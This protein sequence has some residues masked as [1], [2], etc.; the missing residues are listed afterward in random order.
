M[1]AYAFL[2]CGSIAHVLEK[3]VTTVG[4]EETCALRLDIKGISRLHA[5]ISFQVGGADP[6][7]R[8][9][10]SSNGTFL[11]GERVRPQEPQ[12]LRHGDVVRFSAYEPTY[13]RFEL[14]GGERD[15]DAA[16]V[17]AEADETVAAMTPAR[18]PLHLPPI[19]PGR[20]GAPA[21]G[22]EEGSRPAA[23][24]RRRS[25][26]G[27]LQV[28]ASQA[29][30]GP[31]SGRSGSGAERERAA[32]VEP[33]V[34][35]NLSET[36]AWG[37]QD[38]PAMP[39]VGGGGS[40]GSFFAPQPAQVDASPRGPARQELTAGPAA[41]SESAALASRALPAVDKAANALER[42][43]R[44]LQVEGAEDS[45]ASQR[46]SQQ[47]AK[48]AVASADTNSSA[49]KR[50]AQLAKSVEQMANLAVNDL[51]RELE[52][53]A[54]RIEVRGAR[55]RSPPAA[56]EATRALVKALSKPEMPQVA[57]RP[58][59]SAASVRQKTQAEEALRAS[60]ERLEGE[61]AAEQERLEERQS[62]ARQAAAVAQQ[63]AAATSR[64]TPDA[65]QAARKAPGLL[66]EAASL[67][68]RFAGFEAFQPPAVVKPAV[69]G[70][71]GGSETASQRSFASHAPATSST[72]PARSLPEELAY[73]QDV[74]SNR[75]ALTRDESSGVL[76]ALLRAERTCREFERRDQ[77]CNRKWTAGTE[78]ARL[79]TEKSRAARAVT[80]KARSRFKDACSAAQEQKLRAWAELED[81]VTAAGADE[82]TA[83]AKRVGERLK[84][85][86]DEMAQLQASPFAAEEE[87]A[88]TSSKL[89]QAGRRRAML[90]R[91]ASDRNS[92]VLHEEPAAGRT[93]ARAKEADAVVQ[94]ELENERLQWRLFKAEE[95]IRKA[96]S[97]LREAQAQEARPA[98]TLP[99]L[100][101]H[102][103]W[104]PR[105]AER[106]DEATQAPSPFQA[107]SL[108]G[109]PDEAS[110]ISASVA[111]GSV[112]VA[113]AKFD[114]E[115]QRLASA[116]PS[117]GGGDRAVAE[118]Y[119]LSDAEES[120]AAARSADVKQRLLPERLVEL[121]K[122]LSLTRDA[123]RD[124][125][126]SARSG[127]SCPPPGEETGRPEAE[128]L[129]AAQPELALQS[130][131]TS[132]KGR[133]FVTGDCETDVNMAT[134]H[135]AEKEGA[136][137]PAPTD[138][139]GA[140]D[141]C[142]SLLCDDILRPWH[143]KDLL[144]PPLQQEI[145]GAA[146][147]RNDEDVVV[148]VAQHWRQQKKPPPVPSSVVYPVPRCVSLSLDDD[149]ED[150][151]DTQ[152]AGAPTKASSS[153]D[154]SGPAFASAR[155]SASSSER[156]G[157]T[158]TFLPA[159][160]PPRSEKLTRERE[161]GTP[162]G[163]LPAGA[164]AA[165]APASELTPQV[166]R[167]EDQV[168]RDDEAPARSDE[169]RARVDERSGL[170]FG[171]VE[172][173]VDGPPRR[174]AGLLPKPGGGG[175]TA[176][177][178]KLELDDD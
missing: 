145:L 147:A 50:L 106:V 69:G 35:R 123:R 85:L 146:L 122:R 111:G 44:R 154:A 19:G 175:P 63:F 101:S 155:S 115:P 28:S 178:V 49:A 15:G 177:V 152:S 65:A 172:V 143:Q 130:E 156:C 151:L 94:S 132:E 53:A 108:V 45:L 88:T 174:G 64:Q 84:Q 160:L 92:G 54:S 98:P 61:L 149:E 59:P 165:D 162:A 97:E 40:A 161:G 24:L 134:P 60:C 43:C 70:V 139:W 105:A 121:Q 42:L 129:P 114:A 55:S 10:G 120:S 127:G 3:L 72:A 93:T 1:P 11:N 9:L 166:Y 102:R 76:A 133:T 67:R 110:E 33:A 91:H 20:G 71:T 144:R 32:S 2:R 141:V 112:S 136:R 169:R 12:P 58:E 137:Q 83:A 36:P 96:K 18:T 140:D 176:K 66:D 52:T 34:V 158:T 148:T 138:A 68:R 157:S 159:S 153:D 38:M 75:E 26:S 164:R 90:E 22:R 4:R 77:V 87:A 29:A 51:A 168:P 124:H 48:T 17:E 119:S 167:A 128:E 74:V 8:D 125:D 31:S 7:L 56:S 13:Y 170:G 89:R 126:R 103:P 27:Q 79:L 41:E 107:P 113:D 21:G 116:A 171:L 5:E 47:A 86:S 16:E 57:H 104:V 95:F 73:W 109:G 142:T 62:E 117:E 78:E 99:A 150:S 82:Q 25:S 6:L 131:P 118:P 163:S 173:E 81:L 14:A 30:R 39:L 100:E 37:T 46:F 23:S 80:Q 135:G